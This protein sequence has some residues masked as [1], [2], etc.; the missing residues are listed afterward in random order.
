MA[1]TLAYWE[2]FQVPV[3]WDSFDT[4]LPV[5]PA[6]AK[7]GIPY[8]CPQC[9][10]R[11]H[12]RSGPH[13]VP[14]FYH[15]Q[16][17]TTCSGEGVVHRAAKA[18]LLY[19]INQG[20]A[21]R[22][23]YSC[24]RCQH[25]GSYSWPFSRTSTAIQE[26]T[27]G[28]YRGDI[29]ILDD[30]YHP[31]ADLEILVSHRVDDQKASQLP[32]PW[33]EL[34]AEFI[35]QCPTVLWPLRSGGGWATPS[36]C[37]HCEP[38]WIP[39]T[40][41]P[42]RMIRTHCPRFPRY[43]VPPDVCRD[44]RFHQGI[45]EGPSEIP[46]VHCTF[47][48]D[49]SHPWKA[50]TAK[51]VQELK[52]VTYRVP[53]R[54]IGPWAQAPNLRLQEGKGSGVALTREQ[55]AVVRAT[56]S[57]V[58]VIAYAGT[59]KTMTLSQLAHHRPGS[60][61]LYLA[62]NKTVAT[63]ARHRIPS[64]VHTMT[65]HALAYRHLA[66]RYSGFQDLR[67]HQLLRVVPFTWIDPSLRNHC[68]RAV[69]ET[70]RRFWSSSDRELTSDNLPEFAHDSFMFDPDLIVRDARQVWDIMQNPDDTRLA[71]T[72]DGYLKQISL[73]CPRLPYDLI[74][75]DEAQDVTPALLDW[76]LHQTHAQQVY[77]GDPFQAIYQFR[78]AV[79]AMDQ[80]PQAQTY[81]LTES[82]RFGSQLAA[83]A[84]RW[85]QTPTGSSPPIVGRGPNTIHQRWQTA[86]LARTNWG[87]LQMALQLL[88]DRPKQPLTFLGGLEQYRINEIMT[89]W[90]L[91][92]YR[93]SAVTSLGVFDCFQSLEDA[94]NAVDDVQL[95][96]WCKV[97]KAQGR[98]LPEQF[99]QLQRAAN[100]ETGS[101][102]LT[103]IHR[104]K[105][106]EFPV[107]LLGSDLPDIQIGKVKGR[108]YLQSSE[109]DRNLWYVAVT[110][111]Q[112]RLVLP[113]ATDYHH[114]L[115]AE[116]WSSFGPGSSDT[117]ENPGSSTS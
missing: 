40:E 6:A 4:P 104:A 116:G 45:H 72:H 70:L 17:N 109:E 30:H 117:R 32:V 88:A 1:K 42:V 60:R 57:V 41:Y 56:E 75:V 114:I 16:P 113:N 76:I 112:Q 62:F 34:E 15:V 64:N 77:V 36:T 35:L 63:H 108:I 52:T 8:F 99:D 73:V 61:F 106:L 7:K 33:V 101:M 86:M 24:P 11:V 43:D 47:S 89:I 90:K 22:L 94:A 85:I 74:V 111:A 110:R 39:L 2:D 67:V 97:V 49:R 81:A 84:S 95:M 55:E 87:V 44:C 13:V 38:H 71:M 53:P 28:K 46:H 48:E 100:T 59:G 93:Q 26:Y 3:A 115:S 68:A 105:G 66:I 103:T 14:H 50:E 78:G 107:V 98:R 91:W 58:R 79:H 10:G 82:F 65:A 69:V 80:I 25:E 9:H 102:L 18:L 83:L 23:A 21:I 51:M 12:L 37:A 96:Q 19:W 54:V 92:R 31:Q 20:Q 27:L 29:V 5:Y